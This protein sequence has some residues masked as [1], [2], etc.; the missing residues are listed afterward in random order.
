M[1]KMLRL[2]VFLFFICIIGAL[3]LIFYLN[4]NIPVEFIKKT[5]SENVEKV[6]GRKSEIGNITGTLF[7]GIEIGKFNVK[8]PDGQ[9][10]FIEVDKLYLDYE[11]WPLLQKKL[12]IKS[13]HLERPKLTVRKDADTY[14]FSDIKDRISKNGA[15]AE[16]NT[17]TSYSI[18]I[19][20]VR[21][22]DGSFGYSDDKGVRFALTS[23]QSA[24]KPNDLNRISGNMAFILDGKTAVRG[25]F[26]TTLDTGSLSAE[27]GVE[28]VSCADYWNHVAKFVPEGV[29]ISGDKTSGEL[30]MTLKGWIPV[31]YNATIS[32]SGLNIVHPKVLDPFLIKESKL[33]I[34][35][36]AVEIENIVFTHAGIKMTASGMIE[37]Y[38]SESPYLD[39]EADV[40]EI[41]LGRLKENIARY[42]ELVAV[43]SID[44]KKNSVISK[45]KLNFKGKIRDKMKDWKYFAQGELKVG[46]I[47]YRQ[48]MVYKV[49]AFSC[50]VKLL[51]KRLVLKSIV[52]DGLKDPGTITIDPTGDQVKVTGELNGSADIGKLYAHVLENGIRH[53]KIESLAGN[54]KFNGMTFDVTLAEKVLWDFSQGVSLEN[55][56]IRLKDLPEIAIGKGRLSGNRKKIELT[57]SA[58]MGLDLSGSIS[59]MKDLKLSLKGK[60]T[61]DEILKITS[62][63]VPRYKPSGDID[64]DITISADLVKGELKDVAGSVSGKVSIIPVDKERL[65]ADLSLSGNMEKFEIKSCTFRYLGVVEGKITGNIVKLAQPALALDLKLK[66][67]E[68]IFDELKKDAFRIYGDGQ[69]NLQAG[70]TFN[71]PLVDGKMSLAKGKFFI[72]GAPTAKDPDPKPFIIPFDTINSPIAVKAGKL[73]VQPVTIDLCDGQ[74][75]AVFNLDFNQWPF[76][77]DFSIKTGKE[78]KIEK[79][80][81]ENKKIQN[82]LN[83]ALTVSGNFTGKTDSV[84]S[85]S[86]SGNAVVKKGSIEFPKA[87]SS[88]VDKIPGL[89]KLLYDEI[90]AD[91]NIR[92]GMMY[93]GSYAENPGA[94]MHA[95]GRLFSFDGNGKLDLE[96]SFLDLKGRLSIM[97]ELLKNSVYDLDKLIQ[98]GL[99]QVVKLAK[100]IKVDL[101]SASD[102][103]KQKFEKEGIPVSFAVSGKVPD[104]LSYGMDSDSISKYA[105][106]LIKA[107]GSKLMEEEKKKAVDKLKSG[108]LNKLL[109][110]GTPDP[111]APATP[112]A[113]P[114]TPATPAPTPAPTPVPEVKTIESQLKGKLNEKI[115]ELTGTTV[116]SGGKING[117]DLLKKLL[118]F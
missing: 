63:P 52:V 7:K 21:L 78:T 68:K 57:E 81:F 38:M 48:D 16:S 35:E 5:I 25:N 109:G 89:E 54:L 87:V 76:T 85:L 113:T 23:F 95:K 30:S 117:K 29:N 59:E 24:L 3:G 88:F 96:S 32:V 44:F 19:D 103:L 84:K 79:I 104:E 108:V 45:I 70:G 58:I 14:N 65:D 11:I 100:L 43:K 107:E 2:F 8:E 17:K 40:P 105:T 118:K 106:D 111:N 93:I 102:K 47:D 42:G 69:M 61:V 55:V 18:N 34:D 51:E 62:T 71:E 73:S 10:N 26:S 67:I 22:S 90:Q 41:D 116:E 115:Q 99:D 98:T 60:K 64:A 86:G 4:E 1:K 91:L 13:I 20:S 50:V 46:G 112:P 27:I 28:N 66:N 110:T 9:A 92:E 77:Y 49:P 53:E 101:T 80:L 114:A 33:K 56:V 97:P 15:K 12:V 82:L 72:K 83:G 75:S 36:K 74:I 39:L 6:T 94:K 31:K 37:Q